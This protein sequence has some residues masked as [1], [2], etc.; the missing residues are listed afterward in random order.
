V[1][2]EGVK[3]V[4]R[5][6]VLYLY[7]GDDLARAVVAS[8]KVGKAVARNRAKRLLREAIRE[9]IEK[10]AG[11]VA[12]IRDRHLAD[13]AAG[14]GL[15]VVM[16]A[17]TRILGARLPEVSDELARLLDCPPAPPAGPGPAAAVDA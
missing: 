7:P 3:R 10:P 1:Y 5:L 14:P 4:G 2:E 17:R 6:F 16:V 13:A 15:W 11:A 9:R 12:A 8:R